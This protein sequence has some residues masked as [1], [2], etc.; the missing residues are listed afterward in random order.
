MLRWQPVPPRARCGNCR[1]D[2]VRKYFTK[3]SSEPFFISKCIG[4][5]SMNFRTILLATGAICILSVRATYGEELTKKDYMELPAKAVRYFQCSILIQNTGQARSP[6]S[7]G[8]FL[9]SNAIQRGY[10]FSK[11]Y[12]EALDSNKISPLDFD[13]GTL[14]AG[15]ILDPVSIVSPN[16]GEE[17]SFRIGRIS[18]YAGF[19]LISKTQGIDKD[20]RIDIP[21]F[22]QNSKKLLD[23][24]CDYE[25]LG[26]TPAMLEQLQSDLK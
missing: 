21:S 23:E 24:Y 15:F 17:I 7:V 4:A 3:G 5:K 26:L 8:F 11:Q 13:I 18:L 25:S 16:R 22:K 2:F 19:D 20:S 12:Y 1:I 6:S 14:P 9:A 10:D